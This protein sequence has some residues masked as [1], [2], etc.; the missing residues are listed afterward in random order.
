MPPR[1]SMVNLLES[2]SLRLSMTARTLG[3]RNWWT[4]P[5]RVRGIEVEELQGLGQSIVRTTVDSVVRSIAEW[6]TLNI[7]ANF[8]IAETF[9]LPKLVPE[10]AQIVMEHP[11][12]I[13]ERC[14]ALLTGAF[15]DLRAAENQ[16]TI[17]RAGANARRTGFFDPGGYDPGPFL[18]SAFS[19]LQEVRELDS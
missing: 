8:A 11:R 16:I 12:R 6:K 5:F 4:I 17:L 2:P 18:A 19:K 10:N 3:R 14:T 9:P 15:D 7:K 1:R 13:S